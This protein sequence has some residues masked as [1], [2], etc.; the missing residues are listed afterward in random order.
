MQLFHEE[1]KRDNKLFKVGLGS[2]VLGS[3]DVRD[4]SLRSDVL[5]K[6]IIRDMRK[7]YS[8]DLN[9]AT[10]F[11]KKKRHKDDRYFYS[12]IRDY[13]NQKFPFF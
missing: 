10:N 7:Y 13:I 8:L 11:I 6:T 2:L 4:G 12:C 3:S 1:S 5:F 9:G